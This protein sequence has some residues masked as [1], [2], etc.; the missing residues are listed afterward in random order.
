MPRRIVSIIS[1]LNHLSFIIY[2]YIFFLD[3]D[4]LIEPTTLEKCLWTLIS[5]PNA[6]FTKGYTIG[7]GGSKYVWDKGFELGEK[8]LKEN[9]LIDIIWYYN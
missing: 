3:S 2:L 4:D 7:F 9:I 5:H 6:G 8:F 1:P